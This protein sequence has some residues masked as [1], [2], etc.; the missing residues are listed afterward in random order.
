MCKHSQMKILPLVKYYFFLLLLFLLSCTSTNPAFLS[1][2]SVFSATIE[3]AE[4]ALELFNMKEAEALLKNDLRP[5]SLSQRLDSLLIT[6][7]YQFALGNYQES[8]KIIDYTQQVVSK[9]VS[10][11]LQFKMLTWQG[12]V[13]I[14]WMDLNTAKEILQKAE[15]NAKQFNL[16]SSPTYYQWQYYWGLLQIENKNYQLA[17]ST[18]NVLL[19]TTDL[20]AQSDIL[21]YKV[22]LRLGESKGEQ[23]LFSEADSIL[24]I[25]DSVIIQE[26]GNSS[27]VRV[28]SL[29]H[30][31]RILEETQQ[32][33]EAGNTYQTAMSLALENGISTNH[34]IYGR[35]RS[36]YGGLETKVG[37]YTKAEE[38]LLKAEAV[39]QHVYG[40]SPRYAFMLG[41]LSELYNRLGDTE[42]ELFYVSK[43]KD[44]YINADRYSD[45]VIAVNNLSSSYQDL[46][47]YDKAE[48]LYR[49]G[50]KILKE[51]DKIETNLYPILLLNYATLKTDM[52]A[53][54][55]AQELLEES[56]SRLTKVYGTTHPY[57]AS[58]VIN[59]AYLYK[60]TEDYPKAKT[61]YLETERLD[62]LTLGKRHPYYIGTTYALA[63]INEL[64]KETKSAQQYY[65]QAN[66]GQINLIYN[67]YSGFDEAIRLSYLAE[68]ERD[69]HKFLS[70]AW[71][72][73][74]EIPNLSKEAQN[75]NL[76]VKN[77]A[78]EFSAQKQIQANEIQDSS[79]LQTYQQW[80]ATKKQLSKS[81]IQTPEEQQQSEINI[82]E[83]EN[84]AELLEKELVRNKVLAMEDLA[85]QHRPTYDEIKNKLATNEAAIDFLRFPYYTPER[86]TDSVYYCALVNRSTFEQPQL[87]FLGE[88]KELKR[89]LRANVRLNGGNYVENK[90]IATQLYQKIWQPLEAHLKGVKQIAISVSGLLHKVSFATLASNDRPPLIK[91][92]N[93]T[94]YD[95]LKYINQTT[96][97]SFDSNQS[98][99]LLGAANFDLDSIQLVALA[100]QQTT[101]TLDNRI[102]LPTLEEYIEE[103]EEA[104][105]TRS[106]VV[107]NY[108][109]A[110]KKEIKDITQQFQSKKWQVNA[111][112]ELEAV[113]E[114]FKSLEGQ[115][116]PSILHIA[117]HGYFFEALKEGRKVPNNARGRIMAAENPLL[118]SGLAFSGANY[119]WKK[120][121]TIPNLE[122][123]ILTAY[124]I[125]NQNLSKTHLVVLSACE[126]GRGDVVSGEGVFGLQRAFKMAGVDNMLIS[127]WKVPDQQTQ[128]LMAAFYKYYLDSNDAANALHQAQLELSK[129]YRS[130]YWG[131]FILAK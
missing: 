34:P 125:A 52:G 32:Y 86:K 42:K 45:Y 80:T 107:F 84:K 128:E 67:Y 21:F 16:I 110:T 96:T 73:H 54:E 99:T 71:R 124:E 69:F 91:Q 131:G 48:E 15:L 40:Y 88:E 60:L 28:S 64:T 17:D 129:Q 1:N 117:T 33:E 12:R 26:K 4:V 76:A 111:Y 30:I 46:K 31:A 23:E 122:D 127:L 89:L 18:L 2:Q 59:L 3:K 61:Y 93:F 57:Y 75:L 47:K 95:N 70:F 43:Q 118:R 6:S 29:N 37:N 82:D 92:Y 10:P 120:G 14:E 79:L 109:P 56:I 78:L 77:L 51:Q 55:P 100:K 22:N 25:V 44:I 11:Q 62:R 53:Y 112:T 65:Q 103:E 85:E 81:Y 27:F 116:A 108:L 66:T 8:K 106:G 5:T 115:L 72:H 50:I 36:N 90:K 98:I 105:A 126:T 19:A 58:A 9:Q 102:E 41:D 38:A 20:K 94:Y 97:P 74:Q 130:F 83:L 24:A 35:L 49:E 13:Y 104:V 123:G 68:T 101:P 113:E 63:N 39:F 121:K 114:R 7:K 87:V 119:A